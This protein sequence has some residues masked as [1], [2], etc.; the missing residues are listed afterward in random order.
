M[1]LLLLLSLMPMA[2][3]VARNEGVEYLTAEEA[4]ALIRTPV[5]TLYQWRHKGVGPR[6]RKVGRK[7]L[8][9][10]DELVA[11]VEAQAGPDAA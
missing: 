1:L 11:W 2:Q 8:Y 10:R 6:A 7:L 3:A 4:A 9:R 5:A